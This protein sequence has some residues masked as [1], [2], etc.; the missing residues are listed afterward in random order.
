MIEFLGHY[1]PLEIERT[2]LAGGAPGW[3]EISMRSS[4]LF[5][6]RHAPVPQIPVQ[7]TLGDTQS[8]SDDLDGQLFVSVERLG[9]PRDLLGFC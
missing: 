2:T 8:F 7:R 9:C 4:R 5:P 1:K 6:N 3:A